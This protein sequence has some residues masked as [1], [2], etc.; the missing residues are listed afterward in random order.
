MI[1]ELLTYIKKEVQKETGYKA[2]VVAKLPGVFELN[3]AYIIMPQDY[4]EQFLMTS[5][6]LAD[7]PFPSIS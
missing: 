1:H 5:Y 2:V 6:S 4:N 3:T 7:F